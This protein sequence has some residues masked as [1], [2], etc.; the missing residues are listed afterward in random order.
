[1]VTASSPKSEV[2]PEVAAAVDRWGR[3]VFGAPRALSRLIV[4]SE[5]KDEVLHRIYTEV[6][7]RDLVAERSPA[8]ERRP[9]APPSDP[10]TIDPFAHTPDSLRAAS[11]CVTTCGGCRGAGRVACTRCGGSGRARCQQCGGTGSFINPKT[12]RSNKCK[13]CKSTGTVACGACADGV[14]PCGVC[15][16]SGHERVWLSIRESLLARVAIVPESETSLAHPQLAERRVL[17]PSEVAA[18]SLHANVASA[19]PLP[20]DALDPTA[21]ATV[22]GVWAGLDRRF[23]RIVRQQYLQLAVPRQDVTY[24]MCGTTGELV[25]S[26]RNLVG[27]STPEAKRPIRRRLILWPILGFV[28]MF[29]MTGVGLSTFVGNRGYFAPAFDVAV[30]VGI[31]GFFAQVLLLGG[32]LRVWGAPAGLRGL[33]VIERA[34]AAVWL[35]ALITNLVLGAVTRPTLTEFDEALA[36]ARLDRAHVVLDALRVAKYDAGQVAA[37]EDRLLLADANA[38]TGLERLKKLD[39][40]TKHGRALAS[41]AAAAAR[42]DR[43]AAITTALQERRAKD[44]I[45]AIDQGFADVWRT[46]P[47]LA[48]L[49]AQALDIQTDECGDDLC[50]LTAAREA[51]ATHATPDRGARLDQIRGRVFAALNA[52]PAP[53]AN[54]AT[55]VRALA[56]VSRTAA[57]TLQQVSGDPE[58]SA[59]ATSTRGW[60]DQERE[61]I[62]FLRADGATLA[63]LFPDLRLV[64]EGVST[65]TIEDAEVY[66]HLSADGVCTGVYVVGPASKR[67][68]FHRATG[69]RLISR[70]LGLAA[71]VPL[72]TKADVTSTTAKVANAKIVARWREGLLIELRIGDA[73]P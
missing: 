5:R 38:T 35:L 51:N 60:A 17:E 53:D 42:S 34:A 50:R 52:R 59:L 4:R 73:S 29:V 39:E 14:V 43:I 26:G 36:T 64:R 40:I 6:V 63:A 12:N 66:F 33:K 56:D 46:D 9:A 32:L 13:L 71:A 47:D 30:P 69:E 58:L 2:S 57:Q 72:P 62:P 18:F 8:P 41:E 24:R 22:Q 3:S 25:L 23:E 48:G 61:K 44:A 11:Q 70:T 37:A 10:A 49:R 19:G 67:R 15:L 28:L 27:A 7:R 20:L 55:Y 68:V 54:T 21:K 45:A 65:V 16:G 1:M 31:L